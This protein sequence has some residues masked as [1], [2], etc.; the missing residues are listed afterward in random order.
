MSG[1]CVDI[2]KERATHHSEMPMLPLEGLYVNIQSNVEFEYQ[3]DI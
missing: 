2:S 1:V 3:L